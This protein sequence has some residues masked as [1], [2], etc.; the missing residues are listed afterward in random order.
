[1]KRIWTSLAGVIALALALTG[2]SALNAEN[3]PTRSGIEDGYELTVFFPDALNLA[4]GAIVKIDGAKVGK[5]KDVSTEN[6]QAKVTLVID[7]KTPLPKGTV[8]R[9]RPTTALGELFVE[10]L[11]GDGPERIKPGTTIPVGDTRSAPTV[12]DGLAAASLLIN[13]G[14]LSQIKTIISE[15]NDSLDG[16]TGTVKEFLHSTNA[17]LASLN[18]GR[19]DLDGLLRALGTTSKLLNQREKEINEAIEIAAP[20]A[21]VLARNSPDVTKLLTRITDMSATVDSLVKATRSDLTRTLKELAP[22][23]AGI[24]GSKAEAKTALLNVTKLAPALDNAVPTDYL[25]LMLVLTM[26]AEALT[27]NRVEGSKR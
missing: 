25:N 18:D 16:R 8:F 26:S 2:C 19:E 12:E 22:V 13:G 15:I 24:V 3:I 9:L 6:F 20:G 5:V 4:D 11:R 17:L 27:A 14:S 1:M 10:V 7:G 21:K 23:V